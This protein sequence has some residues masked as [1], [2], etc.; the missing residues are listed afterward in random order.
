V[1]SRRRLSARRNAYVFG[2]T[3]LTVSALFLVPTSTNR[4]SHSVAGHAP[5]AAGIVSGGTAS[6]PPRPSPGGPAVPAVP[7]VKTVNGQPADTQFGPVQVQ[8]KIRAGRVVSATAIDYPQSS[9][10]DQ[11]I[12]S[13]AIPVLQGETLAAQSARI[14]TVSGAT[15]TSDGYVRSLQ[16]ALDTAHL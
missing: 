4:S 11:E 5:A 3:G 16:S 10:R 1:T 9:G 14:D 15:Y 12:N 13:Y 7:V 8:I 6:S 2:A